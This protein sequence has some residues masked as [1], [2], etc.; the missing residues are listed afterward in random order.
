MSSASHVARIAH[1]IGHTYKT[2]ALR[3]K[4]NTTTRRSCREVH[5]E[6]PSASVVTTGER[7]GKY[8]GGS[9]RDLIEVIS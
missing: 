6:N 7:I 9:N 4:N 1:N 2:S 8:L 5:V 3:P